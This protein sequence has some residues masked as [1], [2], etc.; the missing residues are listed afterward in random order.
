MQ[1]EFVPIEDF[2]FELTLAVKTL[3]EIATP[4][5]AEQ[6]K[7]ILATKYG[8][9]SSI[10]GAT[11]NT[12]NYVFRIPDVDNSPFHR[13]IVSIAD[14]QG[15]LRLGSDYGWTLN[16]EHRAVRSPKHDDR[17]TFTQDLKAHLQTVLGVDL[18]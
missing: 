15:S 14:W 2:Y 8:E 16:D 17:A 9:P 18:G 5:L 7:H 12:Y 1:L 10:A 3:E 13:L 6:V 11:Q 4:G